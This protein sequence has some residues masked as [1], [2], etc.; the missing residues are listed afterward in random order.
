VLHDDI[1]SFHVSQWNANENGGED[2]YVFDSQLNLARNNN[3]NQEEKEKKSEKEVVKG[4]VF[5]VFD[6][7][8]GKG[9]SS[10]FPSLPPSACFV[11]S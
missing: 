8:S 3:N 6:G 1:W 5:G 2:G 11:F 9:L 4:A 10:F 7:H